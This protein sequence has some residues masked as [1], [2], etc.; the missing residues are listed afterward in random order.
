MAEQYSIVYMHHIF[1]IHSSVNGHLVCFHVL[2]IVNSAEM[3]IGVHVSFWIRVFSGYMAK[4]EIAYFSSTLHIYLMLGL[5]DT[6]LFPY[7]R[8]AVPEN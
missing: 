2:I 8:G 6:F 7:D 5:K 3:D 4:S 1:F